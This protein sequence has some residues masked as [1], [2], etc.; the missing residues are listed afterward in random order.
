MSLVSSYSF[1]RR[2]ARL[3]TV[4]V[5]VTLLAA[6]G[7]VDRTGRAFW[8]PYRPNVQQGNWVTA[9]QVEQLRPGMTREQVR[10]VLGTPTLTPVFHAERWDYPYFLKPGYGQV[11][12]RKFTVF[13]END[14]LTRW[15]GDP[16]PNQQPFQPAA[17][18]KE[19]FSPLPVP[20]AVLDPG[21]NQLGSPVPMSAE[22]AARGE[23]RTDS[24]E[25]A[26]DEQPDLNVR[27]PLLRLQRGPAVDPSAVPQ[28][29]R[30]GNTVPLR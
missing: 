11:Q 14:R 2:A 13:F 28:S 23:V 18:G 8:Q 6:C 19:A 3:A 4:A 27:N 7:A 21:M 9:Q 20:G 24:Q 15:E 1:G 12:E 17:E 30:G 26:T 5:A 29:G 25:A 22:Q 16:L 10:F